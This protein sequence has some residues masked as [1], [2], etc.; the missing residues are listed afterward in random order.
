MTVEN[1]SKLCG[2]HKNRIK[3]LGCAITGLLRMRAITTVGSKTKVCGMHTK[4]GM[5]FGYAIMTVETESKV[6]A[7]HNKGRMDLDNNDCSE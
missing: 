6:C 4:N 5:E 7:M 1:E 3:K 2:M